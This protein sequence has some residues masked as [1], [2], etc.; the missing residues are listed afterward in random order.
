[1]K[2]ILEWW[3]IDDKHL[4]DKGEEDGEAEGPVGEEAELE[5]QDSSLQRAFVAQFVESN[6][7]IWSW[8]GQIERSRYFENCFVFHTSHFYNVES[9]CMRD[10]I[11]LV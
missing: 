7:D 3:S 4:A 6:T 11:Y 5:H 9:T 2:N 10:R 1:M 8:S